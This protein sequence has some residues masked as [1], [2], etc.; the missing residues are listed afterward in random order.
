MVF[1]AAVTVGPS[2]AWADK[3]LGDVAYLQVMDGYWQVWVMTADGTKNRVVTRSPTDKARLSWFPDGKRLLVN[4]NQGGL[5]VVDVSNGVETRMDI[6]VAPV[7]D[8]VISPSGERLA[9]S[10]SAGEA[11]DGNDLWVSD[12]NGENRWLLVK[13]E[14]LQHEPVW[15]VDEEGVYFLAGEGGQTHD[16]W[17]ASLD[18]QRLEKLTAGD[19]YHFDVAIGRDGTLAYSGN[20]LGNYEV[21]VKRPGERAVA[22]TTDPGLDARPTFSPQGD[23]LLF[24]SSRG[25]VMNIWQMSL[26][27]G[28][29][30]QVTNT[31]AGARQPVWSPAGYGTP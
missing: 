9:F 5:F 13:M 27:D 2:S 14:G 29:L 1:G 25:G 26:V 28:H 23:R 4:D 20:A 19:L 30:K 15:D 18:G 21:Y 17:Y 3:D 31:P 12:V 10:F 6:G 7:L 8:A 11:I 24:E 16:I 22:M